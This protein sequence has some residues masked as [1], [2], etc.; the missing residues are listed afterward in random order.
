MERHIRDRWYWAG[1]I[2]IAAAL[3]AGMLIPRWN[4]T[5]RGPLAAWLVALGLLSLSLAAFGKGAN[6]RWFG[7]V[8][9]D[10]YRVSLSRAQMAAWTILAIAAVLAGAGANLARG[11]GNALDITVPAELWVLMGIS[12]L[13]FAG[14]QLIKNTQITDAKIEPAAGPLAAH[15]TDVVR[16]EKRGEEDRLDLGKIQMLLLTL[17]V[18]VAYG[19]AVGEVLAGGTMVTALPRI[20]GGIVTLL[21]VSHAGYLTFKSVPGGTPAVRAATATGDRG[22]SGG[23]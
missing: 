20:N 15:V 8:I 21:A 22:A 16:G 13:S 12:S 6:G 11:A 23:G 1:L 10:R 17:V 19:S 5:A 18:L 7:A 3:A 14:S 2:A 9:D 4:T